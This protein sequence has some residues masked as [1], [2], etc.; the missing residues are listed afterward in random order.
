[1][2]AI[3]DKESYK[4]NDF[5]HNPKDTI[6][7][8]NTR[9]NG[10]GIVNTIDV[11]QAAVHNNDKV[12]EGIAGAGLALDVLG[13]AI[14]PLGTV[15]A[16][17]IG[18][19]IEHVTPFRVPLDM[20]MGDPDGITVATNAIGNEKDKVDGWSQ[21]LK[22]DL[23]A[24]MDS[25]SGDAADKFKE[26]TDGLAEGL[27]A[28]GNSLESAKKTMS[29][30]GAVIGA[31]RGIIRDFIAS[32]LGGILAGA[33]AAVAAMPFTFGSSIGIFLGT[34]VATVAIAM[35]KI[36]TQIAK[37]TKQLS[38]AAKGIKDLGKGTQ[39]LGDDAAKAADDTVPTSTSGDHDAPA[40][41]GGNT[42]ADDDPTYNPWADNN[43]NSSHDVPPPV[44]PKDSNDVPP[45]V[46]PKDGHDTPESS[47]GGN[48]RA[49]DDPTYNPWA[50]NNTN[51]S[52]D[53][54]P[55]VPPKDSPNT[56]ENSGSGNGSGN[57]RPDDDLTYNPWAD[58]NTNS[59][60]DV[61]PPVP[62]KDSPN[63]PENSGGG[64]SPDSSGGSISGRLDG[65]PNTPESSG[66]GG[67]H[68]TG[69]TDGNPGDAQN[70]DSKDK[71]WLSDKNTEKTRDLFMDGAR[72]YADEHP[73]KN[74]TSQQ[75]DD[76][77]SKMD[78]ILKV[79]DGGPPALEKAGVDPQIVEKVEDTI[80]TFTDSTHSGTA[81][82][83]KST[84]DFIRFGAFPAMQAAGIFPDE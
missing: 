12:T 11:L 50:D 47:G 23:G 84:I 68:D 74:I 10:A 77:G 38:S 73:E 37:L 18:W 61:S 29:I 13:L 55:P 24:L 83:T 51:S 31:I 70:A 35:G 56:P 43:T 76:F 40:S 22:N 45:P 48:T 27:T 62:P 72:K 6:T 7:A 80:K 20:L 44:P 54:P 60:H 28:L 33:I 21:D 9:T 16:A 69:N 17:G 30:C 59:S 42:R 2:S 67:G 63:T 65:G 15:F 1:M 82:I 39:G 66:T 64:N 5:W 3:E 14:D 46:P 52:H 81:F 4:P 49:D 25:W 57:A 32:V 19:L 34:V 79:M 75:L 71:S 53:V 36:A 8:D 26:N 78:R 41:G 58:N